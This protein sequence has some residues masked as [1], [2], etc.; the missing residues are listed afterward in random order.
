MVISRSIVLLPTQ[1][2]KNQI[3]KRPM[4]TNWRFLITC[5]IFLII[6]TNQKVGQLLGYLFT[7]NYKISK[8]TWGRRDLIIKWI[9]WRTSKTTLR[10]RNWA[11]LTRLQWSLLPDLTGSSQTMKWDKGANMMKFVR[12]TPV[13]HCRGS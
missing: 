1:S 11:M 6:T 13:S 4:Q 10:F 8:N 12:V 7:R 5:P 3:S 2:S 9:H